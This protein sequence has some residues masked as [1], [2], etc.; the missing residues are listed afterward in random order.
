MG[1]YESLGGEFLGMKLSDP[2]GSNPHDQPQAKICH[3][4]QTPARQA[5]FHLEDNDLIVFRARGQ[6]KAKLLHAPVAKILLLGLLLY[7][8][9][10]LW[11][12]QNLAPGNLSAAQSFFKDGRG[13]GGS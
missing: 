2:A 11:E 6:Q 12:I 1:W 5:A 3:H 7:D 10:L 8:I 4:R 9:A 13:P